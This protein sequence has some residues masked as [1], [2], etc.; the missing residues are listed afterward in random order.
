MRAQRWIIS[1]TV[2]SLFVASLAL[3]QVGRGGSQWLTASGDA[4][5]TSWVRT[6]DK[7]SVEA[8]E[9]PGFELQWKVKLDN[10]PRGV[11]G[12]G[13][14]VTA[15]GVTLFVPMS[16]VTGSSNNIYGID[17]DIGFIVWERQFDV[18]LPSPT[19][20]CPGGI[21]AGATRIVR[22]DGSVSSF[23][24][25]G[26]GR[27]A[28]GYRSL[29]G[30]PG[31]GVP[32]EGQPGGPGARGAGRG[33]PRAAASAPA[34][35][36][37]ARGG[38]APDRIPGSP[39]T[40]EGAGGAFGFLF[41]PSGVVY[42]ITSD[43]MLH[44]LGLASG[45]D[46]QRPAPFLP[47]NAKWSSPIAVGTT[48]YTATS[49]GCGGAPHAVWSI[50]LDSENKPVMSWKTNGGPIVG[51]VAFASDGTLYAAIG[52]A[53][54][55]GNGK[56]NAIVA[57]DPKTLQLK[58]WF[59]QTT[60]EFASGPTII[61]HHEQDIV[62]A[63]TKDGRIFL[64]D[65]KSLGGADHATPLHASK[66]WRGAE[67]T[68]SADALAAWR[69]SAG[70]TW[71]LMPVTGRLATGV[72]PTNG[73]ISTGAILALKV[74]GAGGAISLHAGWTS[75]NLSV[76]ATPMTINGVMFT[77]ATGSSAPAGARG[78]PAVLHAYDGMTGKR[79]WNS[80]KTMTTFASPGSLWTGLGQVYVG[81][82]DGTLY[83]FGFDDERW[84]TAR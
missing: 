2:T 72:S 5:R 71:I 73:P 66:P 37:G 76:P 65:A 70:T 34:Q 50:D 46:I 48:L 38:Q 3:A 78:M 51:A 31:Q 30:E 82:Q 64:L 32:I 14:G 68:L 74:V 21:S 58:D 60:A 22:L 53:P 55:T 75:H 52:N 39:R 61:K 45:K 1:T 27:G 15:S 25:F 24:G 8:L 29:L 84:A 12:L 33:A 19:V 26:G 35:T 62:V 28:V 17:N 83:A 18:V 23:P 54:T 16:I 57:L 81:G 56:A 47:A 7:I 63:A 43:G 80:G 11:H 13:Q 4:Q 9:K 77:L 69:D 36:P 59:T 10:R 67:A 44:V 41:R 79:L 49:A 20:A 42:A 40:E 6:D